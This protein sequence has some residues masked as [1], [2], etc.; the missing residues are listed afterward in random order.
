MTKLEAVVRL[1]K[2]AYFRSKLAELKTSAKVVFSGLPGAAKTAVF[3]ALAGRLGSLVLVTATAA[4]AEKTK[5]EFELMTG[6][7]LHIFPA[8]D[9]APDENV[10][11][12]KELVGQ[13]HAILD[14]WLR[15]E[16]SVVVMSVKAALTKT[17]QPAGFSQR[18][19]VIHAGQEVRLEEL[20]ARLVNLDY[21]RQN[22]VGE[23]GEFSV[24][25]GIV[26]VFPI[27]LDYP[28]RLELE[29]DTIESIRKFDPFSQRSIETWREAVFLP[30]RENYDSP[31][32]NYLPDDTPLIIDEPV[33]IDRAAEALLKDSGSYLEPEKYLKK[34]NIQLSSFLS[35]AETPVFAPPPDYLGKTETIPAQALIVSRHAPS[36]REELPQNQIIQGE[37]AGGFVFEGLE[38]LTDREIFGETRTTRRT[39]AA[40]PEG[41]AEE[42]LADLKVGDYVVHENYGI[43]IY[44]GMKQL[45]LDDIKQEY[46]LIEYA[47]GDK[48]Y[49]PPPMI[50]LVEKYSGGSE[51]APRLSRLG[52]K[53]W[54]KTRSRVKQ[55]LRDLT[56]ELLALYAKRERIEGV[57]FPPDDIWQKELTATFPYDETPDQI[58]AIDEVKRD[59][60]SGRPM[61]RLV[62]GDVGYGKTEVAIR[63]AAKAAS[64]GKQV[65][66]LAPTTILVEQHYNNFSQRFKNTPYVVEM[67]SRFRSPKEQ[68]EV[69]NLIAGGGA[70]IV[71]GT[72]RLLSKD[73]KFHD[74]GLLIIDEEQK[75]G[76]THKEKMKQLK[77]AVDVLTL[78][79]TPIPRTLYFSLAGARAMSL[80]S[81]PPV[82]RSPIRTYVL[83]YSEKSIREAVTRELD[84]GG[85]VYFVH[86]YVETIAG[87]AAMIKKL[88]PEAKVAV[89]HGQMDE[90]ELEKTMLDFLE[91]KYDVLVCTSIIESG[92]DITNVNT[93][94]IDRADRFGLSQLYQIR[95][96]VGRSAVRAYAYLFYHPARSM[97]DQAVERLKAI[98]EFTAL[99]SGYKLAMRDLEI[100]G[101]GNLL[102]AEQSGHIY[103][104]GFDLYCELLEEAVKEVRG[105]TVVSPREVD[106][107]LTI[108]ASIPAHY[109]TDERQRIALYRRMNLITNS[110]G[111]N[112]LKKEMIDRFG[113][114]P[115]QI[116]TLFRLLLLKV[117]ALQAGV[118]SIKE[119]NSK[120]RIEW[121]S[122]KV[123]VLD[124][125]KEDKIR[126][127][128]RGIAE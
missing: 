113:Q 23:R 115:P 93:I 38:V 127:A 116:E 76:V 121:L 106:I 98:Q 17:N 35:P 99:G 2:S 92:L 26:D 123:R 18:R 13:R 48:L 4:S 21:Q 81:T 112:N 122:K 107:E 91:K 120:V 68:K 44:Q 60:E 90:K 71:I 19:L 117:S 47:A 83:P 29:G 89:G 82:D 63:A 111:V 34:V 10:A 73:I 52:T 118:K 72:H 20:I 39:K 22:I 126:L 124:L 50:G 110:E 11:P 64:A 46:L 101:A 67:L 102:G 25:G 15:G 62:C 24:R 28:V 108:E 80:I 3:A 125:G 66:L 31:V 100:R 33:E 105:E 103:E 61:D 74:L 16:P 6:K 95:G 96:R 87:I 59:M 42:L 84:R 114:L 53:T 128:L 8:L 5:N 54:L 119:E 109:V 65:A 75:F 57:P 94:L 43:G 78:T 69:V 1:E 45:E 77:E 55:S 12:S 70:D 9:V 79:A 7:P 41:V 14:R 86:N 49:V 88:V 56:Q 30:A 85:Q 58:K 36:L 104:V 32:F 27:S 37:L 40:V 51:A 97:S